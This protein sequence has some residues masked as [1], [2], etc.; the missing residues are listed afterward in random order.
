LTI[1]ELRFHPQAL[2]SWNKLREKDRLRLTRVLERRTRDPYIPKDRLNAPLSDC[3]KIKLASEGLRL[4]YEPKPEDMVLYVRAIGPR[5]NKDV[6]RQAEV[7][8]DY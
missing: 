2:K 1:W 7:Q 4:I 8:T 5:E 3:Y 6:Y